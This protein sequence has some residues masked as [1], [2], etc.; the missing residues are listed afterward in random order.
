MKPKTAYYSSDFKPIHALDLALLKFY[1]DHLS[2]ACTLPNGGMI[3]AAT[4]ESNNPAVDSLRLALA[5]LEGQQAVSAQEQRQRHQ[6]DAHPRKIKLPPLH[7]SINTRVPTNADLISPFLLATTGS[8]TTSPV[9]TR[10]AFKEYDERVLAA[11][12]DPGIRIQRLQGLNKDEARGLM[13]Y[14]ARSGV[15][16]SSI[17][18]N[19]IGERWTVAGGG[20]I[21]ELERSC[22]GVSI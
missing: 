11:F 7:S 4:S 20:V 17:T 3:L 5:Q 6:S 14:W 22:V 13:E 9:P 2:G 1:T 18:E 8:P 19:L 15:F 16:R 10:D 12:A 21:G